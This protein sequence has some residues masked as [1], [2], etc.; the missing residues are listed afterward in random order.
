MQSLKFQYS[1]LGDAFNKAFKKYDKKVNYLVY[2]SVHNFSKY[3][4]FNFNEISSIDSKFDT[5]NKFYKDL[6]KSDNVKSRDDK[7]QVKA[8][9][10]KSA[11]QLCNKWIDM[12]KKEYKQVFEIKDED[13]KKKHDY[14]HLKDFSYQAGKVNKA[15]VTEKEDETDQELPL[16]IKASKSRFNE[17]R[18]VITRSNESKLMIR[19][20]KSNITL[21]NAE[22]LLEDV[23]SGKIN[24][25]KARNMYDNIAND[26]NK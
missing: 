3:S 7:K 25:K 26:V 6:V 22:K 2:S 8:D 17:K 16:W 20:E 13:W 14:K 18:D 21:K 10:L 23:I 1:P 9:V 11:T 15:D 19:L 12:Y 24:K 4:L 5:I